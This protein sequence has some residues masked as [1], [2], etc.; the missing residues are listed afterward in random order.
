MITW[1]WS[2]CQDQFAIDQK[3]KPCVSITE[4][5]VSPSFLGRLVCV[6]IIHRRMRTAFFRAIV[7]TQDSRVEMLA[8]RA[9]AA[10][11]CPF[12]D[13][14]LN[15]FVFYHDSPFLMAIGLPIYTIQAMWA[16]TCQAMHEIHIT[17]SMPSNKLE[18][19]FMAWLRKPI[20]GTS[21]F[22]QSVI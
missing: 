10:A 22:H 8:R 13:L 17:S 18:H 20:S 9:I 3:R 7:Y 6:A 5:L 1:S 2:S 15:L 11:E 14:D 12:R 4:F 19:S 21:S 16:E